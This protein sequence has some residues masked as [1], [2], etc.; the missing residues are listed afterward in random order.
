MLINMMTVINISSQ[1]VVVNPRAGSQQSKALAICKGI[2]IIG[3]RIPKEILRKML[4]H[5]QITLLCILD[6]TDLEMHP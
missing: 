2:G 1:K 3:R 4:A 5:K 6:I